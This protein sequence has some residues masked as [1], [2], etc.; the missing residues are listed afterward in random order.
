MEKELV[1]S[2]CSI[3]KDFLLDLYTSYPDN[4]LLILRNMTDAMIYTH[5]KGVVQ[6]FMLCVNPYVD[7]I[8]KKNDLFF[9]DGGLENDLSSGEYS[10]L[11]DEL[12]KIANIWR[13]SN[14]TLN[15]KNCIWKYLIILVKLGKK[16]T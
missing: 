10:F 5:P 11:L 2:F 7:K 8:L 1:D 16:V 9:L 4:S 15:T 6:N 13:D 14:T 12:K 3:L